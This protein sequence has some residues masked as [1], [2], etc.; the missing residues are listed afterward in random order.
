MIVPRKASVNISIVSVLWCL[1]L[2]K[3]IR[4]IYDFQRSQCFN[5]WYVCSRHKLLPL[6]DAKWNVQFQQ[7]LQIFIRNPF[8]AWHLTTYI[9]NKKSRDLKQERERVSEWV[10]EW[11]SSAE[12]FILFTFCRNPVMIA[13]YKIDE[14]CHK[15]EDVCF[16]VYVRVYI[17]S[18]REWDRGRGRGRRV[19]V[20]I[21]RGFRYP[22]FLAF[23]I[24]IL[25]LSLSGYCSIYYGSLGECVG[26]V[27]AISE[28]HSLP[29]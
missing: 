8:G 20:Y 22:F 29:S 13:S 12:E 27:E 15:N 4:E 25:I 21:N 11:W 3:C 28:R 14:I 18:E 23:H 16:Y 7:S 26:R 10:S 5:L 6:S 24:H 19:C 17:G 9:P 1:L 2:W